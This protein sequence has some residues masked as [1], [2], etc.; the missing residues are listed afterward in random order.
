M[1]FPEDIGKSKPNLMD[2]PEVSGSLNPKPI[3]A[4]FL[5]GAVGAA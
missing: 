5:P 1:E 4:G 2:F 3:N